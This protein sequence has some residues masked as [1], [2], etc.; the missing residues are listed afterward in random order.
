MNARIVK[1]FTFITVLFAVLVGFTSWWSVIDANNLK[2]QRV[3]KRPLFAAQQIKRGRIL[4]D[5]GTLIA[6]SVRRGRGA[7]AQYV[8]EYPEGTTWGHPI[9]YSFAEQG[10]SEFEQFHNRELIGEDSEF[11]SIIDQL[12][13]RRQVGH[14]VF[15]NLVPAAQQAAFDGLAG[16]P[17]AVVAI[18]PSTGKVRA[19]VS[20]PPYDPN[21]IPDDLSELNRDPGSPLLDRVTQ[22]Q[23]PPGSTF[24]LVTAAAAI[25]SGK[26][27]RETT[28]DAPASINIQGHPLSNDGGSGFGEINVTTALTHSVNTFFAKLGR[29][30]GTATLFE[31]M[32]RFGFGSKPEIDLP[33]DQLSVSGVFI[34]GAL[35][36]PDDGVD[37]ARIAIGQERLLATPIQMAEVAATIANRGDLM[38][39]TLWREVRDVDGRTRREMK[40][41][42]QASVISA[43]S[44]AELTEAMRAVVDEGTGTAAALSGVDVAGK[45]GTAEVPDKVA[46]AGLPNQAWFV[47]FAPADDPQIAVA[48]TVECTDGQGGTVAAPIA[49]SVMQTLIGG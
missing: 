16:R 26:I 24:K 15:T 9:G 20:Q 12:R 38:K 7:S 25:D 40:P 4:A 31:Y 5:D 42:K 19:L 27:T 33:R 32:E 17:G 47:G 29:R 2:D 34:G 8:R 13:G 1:L 14:D 23:Y 48:A 18:E 21:R 46:C 11:S 28:I 41:E 45:T 30:V 10:N 49:A 6:R 22:G 43:E 35:A 3:N 44:A 37:V 39:P 36:G